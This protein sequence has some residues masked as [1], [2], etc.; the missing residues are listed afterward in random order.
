MED[1]HLSA[2]RNR[3]KRRFRNPQRRLNACSTSANRSARKPPNWR[4]EKFT[5]TREFHRVR[6][7]CARQRKRLTEMQNTARRIGRGTGAEKH[8]GSKPARTH[9]AEISRGPRRR[10]QRVHHHTYADE[11]PAKVQTLT[12][13]EMATSGAATD[14]NAVA[15]QVEALQ[16][17]RRNRAGESG[18]H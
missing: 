5:G 10:P 1:P 8:V 7:I 13:E 12:P 16:K 15:Q 3:W 9:P 14:W 6:K 11:G 18:G 4:A 2:G 17:D